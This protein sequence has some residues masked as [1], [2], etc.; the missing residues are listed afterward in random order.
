M[1][2]AAVDHTGSY[3]QKGLDVIPALKCLFP[4]GFSG[5][6]PVRRNGDRA[7]VSLDLDSIKG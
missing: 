2:Q 6:P 1:W 7:S 4:E 3:K 5:K